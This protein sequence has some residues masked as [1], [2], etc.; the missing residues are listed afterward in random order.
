M[1]GIDVSRQGVVFNQVHG[2]Y[3]LSN[4][5]LFG[6]ILMDS[7]QEKPPSELSLDIFAARVAADDALPQLVRKAVAENKDKGTDDL[8]GAIKKAIGADGEA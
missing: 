8:L 7:D 2:C 3:T 6:C 4:R 5:G 1:D